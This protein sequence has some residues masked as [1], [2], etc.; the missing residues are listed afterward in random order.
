V[1]QV[2]MPRTDTASRLW[3]ALWVTLALTL[4]LGALAFWPS[5]PEPMP[6]RP[7]LKPPIAF[8]ALNTA[9]LPQKAYVGSEAT[10]LPSAQ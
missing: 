7:R 8:D 1:N 10:P 4:S 3:R 2:L 6:A 5:A 9:P